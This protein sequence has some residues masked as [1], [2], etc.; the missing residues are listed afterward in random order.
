[1][2]ST[3][4]LLVCLL[5]ECEKTDWWPV[6]SRFRCVDQNL[7]LNAISGGWFMPLANSIK[8][9]EDQDISVYTLMGDLS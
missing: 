8:I 6:I 5:H 9:P 4:K 1:M 7:D 2:K 3:L